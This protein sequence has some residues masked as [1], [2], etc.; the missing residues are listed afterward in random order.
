MWAMKSHLP[1]L[2]MLLLAGCVTFTAARI[3]SLNAQVGYYLPRQG[4]DL[5]G[6][7][8]DGEWRISGGDT[9]RDR[10]RG[11]VQTFGL[12]QYLLAP[13]LFVLAG[14]VSMRSRLRWA[15]LAASAGV[16]VAVV[17]MWLMVYR[18]Y[19]QSLGW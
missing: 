13:A 5:G 12:A 4:R 2:L 8:A 16:L 14:I 10:L 3:E 18:G 19:Y 7:A 11:V 15:R 17:A 6:T 9:P 1:V